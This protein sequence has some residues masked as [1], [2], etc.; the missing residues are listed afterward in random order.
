MLVGSAEVVVRS[1]KGEFKEVKERV[2]HAIEGR[3]LVLNYTARI[4]AMLERTGKDIGAPRQVYAEAEML[5]F[6]SAKISRDTMEADPRNIVIGGTTYLGA[7][8]GVKVNLNLLGAQ[9]T[10]GA[11]LD[12]LTRAEAQR[13]A[14]QNAAY[15]ERFRF[16]LEPGSKAQLG[17]PQFPPGTRKK[18]E[19]FAAIDRICERLDAAIHHRLR[20]METRLHVAEARPG[21]AGYA[22]RMGCD[23]AVLERFAL[24]LSDRSGLLRFSP[25]TK[26]AC[27]AE[28]GRASCRERV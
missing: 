7:T 16:A 27:C 6:C 22:G 14:G 26:R 10:G 24:S 1:T 2:L 15:R 13:V 9:N 4:G 19:F 21:Y 3:G 8:A 25:G 18:D 5:E 11:G 12:Q 17:A 20:R 23:G 28:I